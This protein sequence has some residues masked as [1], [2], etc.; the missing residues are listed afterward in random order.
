MA[1]LLTF[2]IASDQQAGRSAGATRGVSRELPSEGDTTPANRGKVHDHW[3]SAGLF[4][5]ALFYATLRYNVFKGVPWTDW[6]AY[7]VN[8]AIAVGS[9]LL[10]AAAV[11][12]LTRHEAGSAILLAWGGMLALCHSLLSFA[13]LSPIYFAKLFD[14]GKLTASA[15]LSL[16][17][18]ALLLAVMDLGARRARFWGLGLRHTTLALIAF[19]TGIHAALPSVSSW[20]EPTSWPGSLPPLTLISFLTGLVTLGVWLKRYRTSSAMQRG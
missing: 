7:T 19:G 2:S 14:N 18:G 11:I 16:T 12:R 8:K 4:A 1:D 9:L 13:L 5:I 15:G 6:P 3:L 20:V 10:I 17:L